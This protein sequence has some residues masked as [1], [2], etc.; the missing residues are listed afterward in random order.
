MQVQ[1]FKKT[2]IGLDFMKKEIHSSHI[3][4]LKGAHN[5]FWCEQHWMWTPQVSFKSLGEH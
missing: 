5:V 3:L 1:T 4:D 2:W